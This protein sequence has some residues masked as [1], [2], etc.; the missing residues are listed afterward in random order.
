MNAALAIT[1]G[2]SIQISLFVTPVLVILGYFMEKPMS[3]SNVPFILSLTSRLSALPSGDH[4]F[5]SHCY[6]VSDSGWEIDLDE[7]GNVIGTICGYCNQLLDSIVDAMGMVMAGEFWQSNV[8]FEQMAIV[9]FRC[10][11]IL[12]HGVIGTLSDQTLL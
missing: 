12:L 6:G 3:L 5:V 10:G 2:S 1:I 7:R 4:I 11:M 9:I 8:A